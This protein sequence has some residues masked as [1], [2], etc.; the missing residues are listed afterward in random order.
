MYTKTLSG[1]NLLKEN[2]IEILESFA[3]KN[4]NSDLYKTLMA[5]NSG[6]FKSGMSTLGSSLSKLIK[7]HPVITTLAAGAAIGWGLDKFVFTAD[8]KFET[9]QGSVTDYQ[10]T[11]SEIENINSELQTTQ[12]RLNE[13]NAKG[14][15]SLVEQDEYNKLT[16]TNDQLERQ[17]KVQKTLQDIKADEAKNAVDDY[18]QGSYLFDK[19]FQWYNPFT[20]SKSKMNVGIDNKVN[21]N[22]VIDTGDGLMYY[23]TSSGTP[24][25][26]I[27]GVKNHIEAIK[28]LNEEI[29]K[30]EEQA[31]QTK[32]KSSIENL[33]KTIGQK[34][35]LLI[36]Y[37]EWVGN[38][39][40]YVS[41]LTDNFNPDYFND[42][43]QY[44]DW[45]SVLNDWDNTL[46]TSGSKIQSKLNG[47]FDI[48]ELKDS[49]TKDALL[50]IVKTIDS[51][52]DF[53]LD[54]IKVSGI[55]RLKESL[56]KAGISAESLYQYLKAIANDGTFNLEEVGTQLTDSLTNL[57]KDTENDIKQWV[58]SLSDEELTAIA[59]I[60]ADPN[61]DTSQWDIN[62]W[63]SK[64]QEYFEKNDIKVGIKATP[65]FDSFNASLVS[66]NEGANYDSVVSSL[67]KVQELYNKG[68]VGT[69]DFLNF[70]KFISPNELGTVQEYEKAIGKIKKYFTGDSSGVTNFMKDLDAKGLGEFNAQTGELSTNFDNVSESARK[71]GMSTETFVMMFQK[72][73]EYGYDTDIYS[74]S[75][76]ALKD[77]QSKYGKLYDLQDQ[78]AKAQE[79]DPNSSAVRELKAEIDSL[80]GSI[81]KTTKAYFNLLSGGKG[82]STGVEGT[83]TELDRDKKAAND[84]LYGLITEYNGL[85]GSGKIKNYS[86]SSIAAV[87]K[88]MDELATA[89]GGHVEE[90]TADGKIIFK[91]D[92]QSVEKSASEAE[93]KAQQTIDNN[94]TDVNIPTT[95]K[96]ESQTDKSTKTEFT[97]ESTTGTTSSVAIEV[98]GA[99]EVEGVSN[100]IDEIPEESIKDIKLTV[101][102]SSDPKDVGKQIETGFGSGLEALQNG[103]TTLSFTVTAD[104]ADAEGKIQSVSYVISNMDTN[105]NVTI[106]AT[107]NTTGTVEQVQGKIESLPN[108]NIVIT[109]T[110]GVQYT[111][112]SA[113][114]ALQTLNNT[115]ASPT[116]TAIDNASG[117]ISGIR[118]QLS[119]LVD[120]TITVTTKYVKTVIA[121]GGVDPTSQ[122]YGNAFSKGNANF[123]GIARANGNIGE[124]KDTTALTG[125][126]GRELVVRGNRWFTV[127]DNGA[128][129]AKF[130]KND[131]VFNHRQTEEL[132]KHG[133]TN[134]RGKAL[135][136]GNIST[137]TN[138][139][140]IRLPGT[141][142][143]AAPN[144]SASKSIEK[145]A[146]STEKAAKT[147]EK[148]AKSTEKA[149]E[150]TKKTN[151]KI[152]NKWSA[153]LDTFESILGHFDQELD[154]W[155]TKWEDA[156]NKG[157]TEAMKIISSR[158]DKSES[159]YA[160]NFMDTYNELGNDLQENFDAVVQIR[161]ELKDK[162][163]LDIVD[164]KTLRQNIEKEYEDKLA[165][166]EGDSAKPVKKE[167]DT[168]TSYL[169]SLA[170]LY[171][172]R[173][174]M[175]ESL[176]TIWDENKLREIN[177]AIEAYSNGDVEPLAKIASER[178]YG[179]ADDFLKD[180]NNQNPA[181]MGWY[182]KTEYRNDNEIKRNID[183]YDHKVADFQNAIDIIDDELSLMGNDDT[184]LSQQNASIE[185]QNRLLKEQQ[186]LLHAKADYMRREGYTNESSEVQDVQQE[187]RK[188]NLAIAENTQKMSE[189]RKKAYENRQAIREDA[190]KQ[191]DF[192]IDLL[193]E[194]NSDLKNQYI[195]KNID[196]Y[197]KSIS[198]AIN[199]QKELNT[200]LRNG[201]ITMNDY[202][203][204]VRENNSNIQD[205]VAAL[206]DY[207]DTIRN[208]TLDNIQKQIDDIEDSSDRIIDNLQDQIDALQDEKDLLEE[209]Q[210]KWG[211]VASAAQETIRKQIKSLE[212]EKDSATEYWDDQIK[213]VQKLNDETNRNIDLSRAKQNLEKA[214]SQ[215]VSMVYQN[216]K[217]VAMANQKDV[218]EA[219]REY[220][221]TYRQIEQEKAIEILE[222]QR[223]V[224]VKSYEDRIKACDD[225]LEKWEEVLGLFDEYLDDMAAKEE[226]GAD[227]RTALA[228]RDMSLLDIVTNAYS[229][230]QSRISE[231]IDERIDD[232]NKQI[233]AQEKTTKSSVKSLKQEADAV[234][235]TDDMFNQLYATITKMFEEGN[236]DGIPAIIKTF[237]AD[238]NE[239]FNSLDASNLSKTILEAVGNIVNGSVDVNNNNNNNSS[240]NSISS[241]DKGVLDSI[242]SGLNGFAEG[243]SSKDM[244]KWVKDQLEQQGSDRW[245]YHDAGKDYIQISADGNSIKLTKGNNGWSYS[246]SPGYT[247]DVDTSANNSS[248]DNS[249]NSN[250]SSKKE[251]QHISVN[252]PINKANTLEE[253]RN[254]LKGKSGLSTYNEQP[255]ASAQ[256]AYN[257]YAKALLSKD[258]PK[259]GVIYGS[260]IAGYTAGIFQ[261][262]GGGHISDT[263]LFQAYAKGTDN[264]KRGLGLINEEGGEILVEDG[265]I[266]NFQGGE[267][268]IPVD[269]SL[270]LINGL[271]DVTQ[272]DLRWDRL[273]EMMFDYQPNIGNSYK[274]LLL[275][276]MSAP[277][278]NIN[279]SNSVNIDNINMYEV[280]NSQKL[281]KDMT[282]IM[283]GI[284]KQVNN[285][286]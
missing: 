252:K 175:E 250:S 187:W 251:E 230:N 185:E 17:L 242:V 124:S 87:R 271:R 272:S 201:T 158:L 125:E 102:K 98:E 144:N 18:L 122:A 29:D 241:Q 135:A 96:Q 58:G 72:L 139:N 134:T 180:W 200:E 67:E 89:S 189:N 127:G 152:Y 111:I 262:G 263:K 274:N 94:S 3:E 31:S 162:L 234:E 211:R 69:D 246:I 160:K 46:G 202:N 6:G 197:S 273:R 82:T 247:S 258:T 169:D 207:V 40:D 68:L 260:G 143:A 90:I 192:L 133:Y 80:N 186:D 57:E 213:A 74:N 131:I 99:E 117:V 174:E 222:D 155:Q 35:E 97:T 151:D 227:Y 7:A 184:T 36:Q 8:E 5:F 226:L 172:K 47:I 43:D 116:V 45:M 52:D 269:K 129:F 163:V 71:M 119:S 159:L 193:G 83:L 34:Q 221:D 216:G 101:N 19:D 59:N 203:E 113:T 228:N 199:R 209:Q 107:D 33:N 27:E 55:D 179:S 109:A 123:G 62:T 154:K 76:E 93:D 137:T 112:D 204:Q 54:N 63:A 196:E 205:S 194:D 168:L 15:L 182:Q 237:V 157:N 285:T 177:K 11:L 210:D 173:L 114:G 92:K 81:D 86:S 51:A 176:E 4:K 212:D 220:D 218:D 44:N 153:A 206:R 265:M 231:Y 181:L 53:N 282:R 170:D 23:D 240:T 238:F 60:K 248:S 239:Q 48:K 283:T 115:T 245:N 261:Y 22:E 276:G 26:P 66:E 14:T 28:E 224:E 65:N 243:T 167:F 39:M 267:Q 128:E 165:G 78:L 244:R 235:D 198:A 106:T 279:T 21:G 84:T 264:A 161:P 136:G 91:M 110:D 130:H 25:T 56:G 149:A 126:L 121:N 254:Y 280:D 41:S 88:T 214:S 20:W 190:I 164:D 104:T 232:L 77:L 286:K 284:F 147:S 278:K 64:V 156:L 277:T 16:R 259:V 229:R 146:Q 141:S 132:L 257:N 178:N 103:N 171:D 118:G 268:V 249:S 236:V 37:E 95:V 183:T 208:N 10:S 13:L 266:H 281:A 256:E 12:S 217:F 142:N 233:K 140:N 270:E 75:D 1:S 150:S 38:Q 145:A 50:S 253:A 225:Y 166:L 188:Y 79:I 195:S 85:V 215:K 108:G 219:R 42:I 255:F 9:A 120:K 73:R 61:V 148:A 223:D 2:N 49:G 100:A 70:A 138:K 24:S 105:G 191:N 275:N 32:N 30:L